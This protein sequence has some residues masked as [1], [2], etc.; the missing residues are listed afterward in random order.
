MAVRR[1]G[2]LAIQIR[3]ELI[4]IPSH[5]VL[6][7]RARLHRK[8]CANSIQRS[9]LETICLSVVVRRRRRGRR[10]PIHSAP[11]SAW[12]TLITF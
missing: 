7:G 9:P 2:D 5:F 12:P 8:S 4:P 1:S 6:A 10:R 11:I 3:P